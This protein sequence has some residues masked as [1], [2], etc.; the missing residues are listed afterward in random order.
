MGEPAKGGGL[1]TD[2]GHTE[3]SEVMETFYN[4]AFD[5]G[6]SC[7]VVCIRENDPSYP[8]KMAHFPNGKVTFR[9]AAPSV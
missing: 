8:P 5:L 3:P 2:R 6:A 9:R 7:R 1:V 4:V